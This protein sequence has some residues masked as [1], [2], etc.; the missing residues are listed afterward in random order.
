MEPL[1]FGIC[2]GA[3]VAFSPEKG[4]HLVAAERIAAGEVILCDRPYS[5]VLIPGM[6]EVKGRGGRKESDRQVLFGMEHRRC[7]RCMSETVC[8]VPCVGCSYSRYCSTSCQQVAWEEHHRCECLLGADLMI[9]GVMS[10][11]AL[12]V[13]FKAGL[14][15][16]QTARNVIKDEC[17]QPKSH[18]YSSF[19]GDSYSSVFHLLHHLNRHSPEMTFLCAVTVATLYLKLSKSGPPPA[20]WDFSRP[21]RSNPQFREEEGG[22]TDWTSDLWLLGS[23]ALRHMLQLRCNAQAIVMMQDTGNA[24]EVRCFKALCYYIEV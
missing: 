15:S 23:A 11:L 19:Y 12:R 3:A 14:K 8:P 5:S 21:S 24:E 9:M 6:K 10:Q 16:I 7:H 2:P 18:C 20:S 4:R 1:T 22:I 17:T 13:A